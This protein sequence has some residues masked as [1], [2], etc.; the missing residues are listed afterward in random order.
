ML[1]ALFRL[2][3]SGLV[4]TSN[5]TSRVRQPTPSSFT[6]RCTAAATSTPGPTWHQYYDDD[7][8]YYCV[9]TLHA[10]VFAAFATTG[11][12]V[13]TVIGAADGSLPL[14]LKMAGHSGRSL[15]GRRDNVVEDHNSHHYHASCV[16]RC[17]V[18]KMVLK[19]VNPR[20]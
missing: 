1:K 5:M 9:G 13:H 3:V 12:A 6:D 4:A 8:S 11:A 2:V 14:V 10:A 15:V 18:F 17:W 19:N 7:V 16:H 20:W